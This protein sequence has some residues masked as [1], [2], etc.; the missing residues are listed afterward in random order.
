M[1]AL[2]QNSV[3]RYEMRDLRSLA[4]PCC[5]LGLAVCTLPLPQPPIPNPAVISTSPNLHLHLNHTVTL[6]AELGGTWAQ[7]FAPTLYDQVF[8]RHTKVY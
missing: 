7:S 8:R 2:K 3:P 1:T 6:C 4:L 5:T